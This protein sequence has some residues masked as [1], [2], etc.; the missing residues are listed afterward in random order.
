MQDEIA[1]NLLYFDSCGKDTMFLCKEY[2]NKKQR[3]IPLETKLYTLANPNS[4]RVKVF[5]FYRVIPRHAIFI[6]YSSAHNIHNNSLVVQASLSF[7]IVFN[8]NAPSIFL[9]HLDSATIHK[10]YFSAVHSMIRMRK[11]L[12]T[13]LY[14]TL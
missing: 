1:S 5:L 9:R 10:S 14:L 2:Y 12:N 11:I 8:T 3:R 6:Q 4:E 13:I 7:T